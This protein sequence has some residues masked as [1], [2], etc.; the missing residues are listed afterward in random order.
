MKCDSCKKE[1]TWLEVV[2]AN[3]ICHKCINKHRLMG[4][5][6]R[7]HMDTFRFILRKL[8]IKDYEEFSNITRKDIEKIVDL[9]KYGI[10]LK[11][12]NVIEI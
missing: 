1:Q 10:N 9:K 2:G 12:T 7:T 11:T 5:V 6:L 3:F 4:L 8:D